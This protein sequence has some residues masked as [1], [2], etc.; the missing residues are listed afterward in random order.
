MSKLIE[1]AKPYFNNYRNV[2]GFYVTTD[3]QFFIKKSDA[4]SH[5]VS[6]NKGNKKA[7]KP[8]YVT[9][10]DVEGKSAAATDNNDVVIPEGAPD[11]NWKNDDIKAYLTNKG[12]EFETDANKKALLEL[13]N[14]EAPVQD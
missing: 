6:L 4:Y 8:E 3:G 14:T 13:A 5:Q 12:I 2:D 9:R 11:K 10:E 7:A 1:K